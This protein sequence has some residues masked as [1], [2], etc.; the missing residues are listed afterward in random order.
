MS[1]WFH[2]GQKVVFVGPGYGTIPDAHIV[3]PVVGKVY[4]VRDIT[5]SA[6]SGRAGIR[7]EEIVNAPETYLCVDGKVRRFEV[8]WG[9]DRFRPLR[10]RT[11]DISA[12][13]ALLNTTKEPER[14]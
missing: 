1:E 4:T 2:V 12:F 8:S 13:K 14:A 10:K 5:K 7:V 9:A 11:T 6:S 3:S